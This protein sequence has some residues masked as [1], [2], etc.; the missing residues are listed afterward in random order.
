[1]NGQRCPNCG[2][3]VTENA[4]EGLCPRCLMLAGLASDTPELME[5][6]PQPPGDHA[7]S[8][9]LDQIAALFPQLEVQA[10]LGQGGMGT[11]YK[12]QQKKLDRL[13]ALKTIRADTATDAAFAERFNREARTLARMSHPNIVG[14]HDF[15][16][17]ITRDNT[18]LYYF[19][20]EYVDGP[21]LRSLIESQQLSSSQVLPI[22]S[23]VC[24]ALHYAH[25][26]GV[27]HRDIKPE[28]ILVDSRGRVRIADFG[29]AKLAKRS[30]DSFT[31][32]GTYQVMGTPRYMAPEQMEGSHNVD[33]RADLY[34]L[35]VVFYELLTHEL[36]MGRFDVP[37]VKADS[38]PQLDAIILRALERDPQRRYDSALELQAHLEA[39]E[40]GQS[41]APVPPTDQHAQAGVST[42][43]ERE[44]A[45]AWRWVAPGTDQADTPKRLPAGLMALLSMVG[46]LAALLPWVH[47][48]I[49]I[50]D[51]ESGSSQAVNDL[52]QAILCQARDEIS[53]LRTPEEAYRDWNR[54]ILSRSSE[55]AAEEV[56]ITGIDRS[57]GLTVCIMFGLLTLLLIALPH[58]QNRKVIWLLMMT[59]LAI[60]CLALV[61]GFPSALSDCYLSYDLSC[62]ILGDTVT[63]SLLKRTEVPHTRQMLW[64]WYA[65]VVCSISIILFAATGIR[66]TFSTQ[67]TESG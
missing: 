61:L 57:T 26:E 3:L 5:T 42:I 58:P 12:A 50:P 29:L 47:L 36:P 30:A 66:H 62:R 33:H 18:P 39:V 64:P 48:R 38:D 13:V 15:G 34:S 32:T 8:L 14:I 59:G 49:H 10:V 17:V 2:T 54:V 19:V 22:M 53:I 40:A 28:N 44:A 41:V 55:I 56:E 51:Q 65:E 43:I 67:P 52:Q 37:S 23:Q 35:G 7:E 45:A 6:T 20:M 4:L 25:S 63:D 27:V 24:D 60:G 11:V 9:P 21:N 31:L 46:F 16:E 1:M